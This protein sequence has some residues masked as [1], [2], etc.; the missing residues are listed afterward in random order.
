MR[1]I[2]AALSPV[3]RS[4]SGR[5]TTAEGRLTLDWIDIVGEVIGRRSWPERLIPGRRDDGGTLQIL[6]AGPEALELQH[7][8]P[9]IV[10]RINRHFGHALIARLK[11][12][13]G[14]LPTNLRPRRTPVP[15]DL[16]TRQALAESV[17]TVDDPDLRGALDRLG[18]AILAKR[19]AR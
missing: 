6:V 3:A 2:G 16:P 19:R 18:R 12:R 15:L 14:H 11:W 5:R 7:L 4:L 13:Q 10:E 17:A 8:E 1:S 9:Q